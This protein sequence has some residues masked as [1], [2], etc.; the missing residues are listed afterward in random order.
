MPTESECSGH[1]KSQNQWAFYTFL[2]LIITLP[3][4]AALV[5]EIGFTVRMSY[6]VL[7]PLIVGMCLHRG[8]G[9]PYLNFRSPLT[10]PIAL[11]LSAAALSLVVLVSFPP[12]D[13]VLAPELQLRGS[14]VRG[15]IQLGFLAFS[16]LVFFV[17]FCLCSD[18]KKLTQA[19]YL[20]LIAAAT[21]SLYGIYQ[22]FAHRNDFPFVDITNAIGT[23]GGVYHAAIYI[24]SFYP[25]RAHGT[26]QEPLNFG[27]YL[28]SALPLGL[29]LV[30]TPANG[31][32]RSRYWPG[33]WYVVVYLMFVA[34]ALTRSRGAWLG[35]FA[36]IVT[37]LICFEGERRARLLRVSVMGGALMFFAL[38]FS[39]PSTP[40]TMEQFAVAN[41]VDL[42]GIRTDL[43]FRLLS[44]TLSI[45]LEHPVLGVGLGSY[46]LYQAAHLGSNVLGTAFGVFWQSLVETGVVGFF[47]FVG[48]LVCL[49]DLT[50][51]GWRRSIGGTWEPYLLGYLASFTGLLVQHLSFGD[52]LTF[53]TWF[54]VGAAVSTVRLVERG[55]ESAGR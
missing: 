12:P 19:V 22:V 14:K 47:A 29:A 33:W 5:L 16:C 37:L 54:L 4:E 45:F 24:G 9:W 18:G 38:W 31:D 13:V 53:Y 36:A 28:L 30:V 23:G 55:S 10:V 7:I 32:S 6:L 26:F 42:Q 46:P 25:F 50:I 20:H 39:L 17:T 51:R 2:L 8:S 27:H 49:Y 21:L 35:L 41:R 44:F 3:L 43:R 11:Y 40:E 15:L 34:V 52:R 1:L 48:M